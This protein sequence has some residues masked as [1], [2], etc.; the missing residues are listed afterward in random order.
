[1]FYKLQLYASINNNCVSATY[2]PRVFAFGNSPSLKDRQTALTSFVS[3]QE[4][5]LYC[6]YAVSLQWNVL[7][8]EAKHTHPT[9]FT[10]D[11]IIG[12]IMTGNFFGCLQMKIYNLSIV[13]VPGFLPRTIS[14]V[15]ERFQLGSLLLDYHSCLLSFVFVV[16]EIQLLLVLIHFVIQI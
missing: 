3:S 11:N 9:V 6:G 14:F 15:F 13:M 7:W 4:Q 8:R 2:L 10:A 5:K 1:M 12:V 16:L